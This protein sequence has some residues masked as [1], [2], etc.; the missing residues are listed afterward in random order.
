MRK[1]MMTIAAMSVATGLF[2]APIVGASEENQTDPVTVQDELTAQDEVAEE[3]YSEEEEEPVVE[4]KS[5][6]EIEKENFL[7][8]LHDIDCIEDDEEW[9][10]AY[11]EIVAKYNWE[12]LDLPETIYD[13]YSD[14]ELSMLFKVVQ[15]EVGDEYSFSQKCNA[16]S[17]IYNRLDSEE[18]PD[19]MF[20]ILTK[21]QFASISDGRYNKVE[22]SDQT[23]LACEYAF[24]FK[25]DT[26]G[27]LFFESGN[28]NIHESYADLVYS[29]GV[30][31][32]YK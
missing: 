30:H 15:A 10:L 26:H 18:F 31:K 19:S 6:A 17:V 5:K 21:D 22:V 1:I 23:I 14:E 27:A 11:K 29:D 12:N 9:Y 16:A 8:D 25:D 7:I 32:F 24:T 13:Y 2:Y 3:D 4:Y 20:E 28:N